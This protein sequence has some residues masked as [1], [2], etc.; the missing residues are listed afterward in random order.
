MQLCCFLFVNT[1]TSNVIY[2]NS[3]DCL[4]KNRERDNFHQQHRLNWGHKVDVFFSSSL[5]LS[6]FGAICLFVVEGGGFYIVCLRFWHNFMFWLK[7]FCKN[8][9]CNANFHQ[10]FEFDPIFAFLSL[11]QSFKFKTPPSMVCMFATYLWVP[12]C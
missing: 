6:C 11:T 1:N 10:E 2:K 9:C 3:W 5:L 7:T 4:N 12:G 8:Q